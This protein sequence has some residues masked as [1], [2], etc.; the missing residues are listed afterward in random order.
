M[1]VSGTMK[2]TL[3]LKEHVNICRILKTPKV[4][5]ILPVAQIKYDKI[6]LFL[7]S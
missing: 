1:C 2:N 4:L 5:S 6:I 7:E 3:R